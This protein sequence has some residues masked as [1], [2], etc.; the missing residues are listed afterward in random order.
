MP[1]RPMYSTSAARTWAAG[2]E[3][4]GNI[5]RRH[6]KPAFGLATT[7]VDG[8]ERKVTERIA[9]RFPFCQIT[10]FAREGCEALNDPNLLIGPPLS[11]HYAT[12][13]RGTVVGMTPT[14]ETGKA[15]ER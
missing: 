1:Y 12:L 2:L 7:T 6:P 9:L 4:F 3:L 11:G 8:V 15:S 10:N 13:L 5:T 14:N